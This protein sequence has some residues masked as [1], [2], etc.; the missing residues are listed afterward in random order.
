M[1]LCV[2][3]WVCIPTW[4]HVFIFWN[5][6]KYNNMWN[7]SYSIKKQLKRSFFYSHSNAS[8]FWRQWPLRTTRIVVL[9]KLFF[10]NRGKGW[11]GD[12]CFHRRDHVDA[13]PDFTAFSIIKEVIPSFSLPLFSRQLPSVIKFDLFYIDISFSYFTLFYFISFDCMLSYLVLSFILPIFQS[14]SLTHLDVPFFPAKMRWCCLPL[15]FSFFGRRH[16]VGL[17]RR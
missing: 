1:C 9:R 15:H 12:E 7:I 6:R 4:K 11:N 17:K 13:V 14:N 2:F 5:S 16:I 8:T 3:V 10:G